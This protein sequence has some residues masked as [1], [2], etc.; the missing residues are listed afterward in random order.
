MTAESEKEAASLKQNIADETA[1]RATP[2]QQGL[3][4]AAGDEQ[5]LAS[6]MWGS[7][8]DDGQWA[9]A[10]WDEHWGDE[11]WDDGDDE[12]WDDDWA[13]TEEALGKTAPAALSLGVEAAAATGAVAEAPP[14]PAP[15]PADKPVLEPPDFGER[16]RDTDKQPFWIP[17]AFPT[18]FQNETGDP[19]NYLLKEVDLVTWGP[20]VL[21]SKGWYAQAHMTFMYWWM[22]M[23]QR[24]QALSAKKWY[25]RDNPKATGYTAEDLSKMSVHALAK[26]M[27]GYTGAIPG[28]K[29]SK[30]RLRRLILAMVRQIEIETRSPDG[31]A[32]GPGGNASLGDVPCLFGTLTSQ[33]YH[34]DGLIRVIA[35]VEGVEDYRALSKSKRRELVN[36]YPLF[37]AWYCSV[38]LELSLKAMVVPVF[39][40]SAYVA[41]FEWS[42]TGGMVHLHYVLWKQGA[43]RFDLRAE[44]LLEH[45]TTM[46][47]AGLV[48]A[49]HARCK[50]DDVVDFFA[51]Y[52]SEWNPNK[53]EVGDE[54]RSHVAEQV[55]AAQEHTAAVSVEDMLVLLQDEN[56]SARRDYYER[57]VRT[58]HMHDFHYP[59]PNGA[60]NPSQPCARL[61]KGTMNMWY[62]GNGYPRDLVLEPPK[63]SIAQDPLRPD[64]W[65][66]NL[67]RN[68]PLMN[69]HM[70]PVTLGGQ[71][72][73]DGQPVVTKHQAEMYCCKYC[74]KHNKN[75]GTRAAL[76][77]VMDDM[78][79][80]DASAKE[81]YGDTFEAKKRVIGQT[82]QAS[83]RT[84]GAGR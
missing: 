79:R 3:P 18:I 76:F 33:R 1:R 40:A 80:V 25:V 81:K 17:G 39:G 71:S 78:A 27:V 59:D 31:S 53:D 63:Q 24:I 56:R 50:L 68:C 62:C 9:D 61:L 72:N 55:N 77:E 49:G 28:T 30:A 8:H 75:V 43:P 58:E 37:V 46:R 51:E 13:D 47:K 7:T 10:Q 38:R 45:A 83:N 67:C 82:E 84:N 48:S 15:R 26:Q 73:N 66:C 52:V 12:P 44:Q 19:Y 42:P 69:S 65:R 20:H 5:G 57:A 14:A 54:K 70:P 60:P 22:N 36:K 4:T 11:P 34:W 2:E 23:I 21:R 32:D 29:A 64:L 35:Q 74:S 16:I 41:V 6:G